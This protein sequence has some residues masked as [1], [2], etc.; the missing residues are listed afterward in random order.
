MF[1]DI[2]VLFRGYTEYY[3]SQISMI[4][5]SQ[6]GYQR[7][8]ISPVV[9]DIPSRS[10]YDVK[11]KYLIVPPV[12]FFDTVPWCPQR[13]HNH[14]RHHHHHPYR[15]I[16]IY[17]TRLTLVRLNTFF[18]T[19]VIITSGGIFYKPHGNRDL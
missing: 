3:Y 4:L 6:C 5:L 16:I 18:R 10:I 2:S 9:D 15:R 14:C 11:Y 17:L 12:T 19:N 8:I 1:M 13:R 7:Y